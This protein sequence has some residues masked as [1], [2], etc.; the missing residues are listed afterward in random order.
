MSIGV[1]TG[2]RFTTETPRG[3]RT[4]TENHEQVVVSVYLCVLCASVVD[5]MHERQ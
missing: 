4:A 2:I 3:R 1:I 5:R